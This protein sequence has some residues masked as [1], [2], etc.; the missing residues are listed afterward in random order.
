VR[1]APWR[2]NA[3]PWARIASLIETAALNGLEPFSWLTAALEAI[4]AGHAARRIN[5]L[6]P[7]TFVPRSS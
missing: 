2:R 7:W 1:G 5:E 4:S 6:L 3:W